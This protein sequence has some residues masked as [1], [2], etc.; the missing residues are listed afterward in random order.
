VCHPPP[1]GFPGGRAENGQKGKMRMV[2][3]ETLGRTDPLSSP[4]RACAMNPPPPSQASQTQSSAPSLITSYRWHT[5]GGGE[6]GAGGFRWGRFAGW[7]RALSHQEPIVSSQ[8][9]PRSLFRRVLSAPPKESRTSRL[10]LSKTLWGRHKNAALEPEPEPQASGTCSPTLSWGPGWVAG[11]LG[12]VCHQSIKP[13]RHR[14]LW[15]LQKA[16]RKWLGPLSAL[17]PLST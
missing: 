3:E 14:K 11:C 13:S 9:A 2:C 6:K 12:S 5:G 15:G 7:G 16:R 1:T 10:R 4:N 17:F 8:P